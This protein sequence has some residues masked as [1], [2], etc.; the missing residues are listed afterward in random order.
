M[1]NLLTLALVLIG[2]S[3][4]AGEKLP[5]VRLPAI[6]PPVQCSPCGEAC[7]CSPSC[8]CPAPAVF[9]PSQGA[10]VPAHQVNVQQRPPQVVAAPVTY[11][12]HTHT[13]PR[14]GTRWDH[15]M[16]ASHNCPRC[17]TVQMVQ[18]SPQ[19]SRNPLQLAPAQTFTPVVRFAPAS[20]GCPGGNCN[21]APQWSWR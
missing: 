14:C 6:A 8:Q 20:G 7:K 16:N 11:R 1:K 10:A 4:Y 21:S 3:A 12:G 19:L 5:P 2:A 13:C 17:G 18:D 9:V 15:S